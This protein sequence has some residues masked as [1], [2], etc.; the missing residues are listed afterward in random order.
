MLK[1]SGTGNDE[2]PMFAMC[3]K[4]NMRV[5]VCA[6]MWRRKTAKVLPP[7]SPAEIA[8]VVP[9]NGTSSSAGMP[10]AEPYGKVC[11]CRSMSP[12]TTSLPETSITRFARAAGMSA[13]T[14]STTP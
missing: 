5:R 4:A 13:S 2:S 11:A 6:T 7:A 9:W 3:T 10:I 12:G 14:A 1:S 8:V